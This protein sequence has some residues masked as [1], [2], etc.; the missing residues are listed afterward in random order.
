MLVLGGWEFSY[1]RGPPVVDGPER[2]LLQEEAGHFLS[3]WSSSGYEA[4][5]VEDKAW[6]KLRRARSP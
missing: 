6:L 1:E 2:L 4:V 5:L 3:R